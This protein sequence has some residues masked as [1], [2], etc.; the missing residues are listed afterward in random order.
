LRRLIV[1]AFLSSALSGAAAAASLEVSPVLV[2]VVAPGAASTI[3]IR[4]N[5][6]RPVTAQTRVFRWTQV[7]GRERLDPV[8]DLVVSPP[9]VQLRPRQDYVV[10]IVRINKAPVVGEE[11]YRLLVDDLTAQ[12]S[13]AGTVGFTFRYS[14][15]VFFGARDVA[16]ARMRWSVLRS[17]RGLV[18]RATNEGGQR[19]RLSSVRIND[20]GGRNVSFGKGLVGYVLAGSTMDWRIG[21]ADAGFR[22]G[23]QVTISG[24]S[25]GGPF[26]VQ[27]TVQAGG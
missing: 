19:Y 21:A 20:T 2:E 6:T 3:T 11:S 27:A 16:P 23:S 15:P 4:N 5:E 1:T 14:I 10:R 13:R 26:S 24:D 7:D 8:G 12:Q 9:S 17:A 22:P 18:L 25:E